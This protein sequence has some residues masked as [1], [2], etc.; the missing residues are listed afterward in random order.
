VLGYLYKRKCIYFS[1]MTGVYCGDPW[2]TIYG[3]YGSVM[4][5]IVPIVP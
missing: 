2:H 5:M 4:G 1:I 3:L